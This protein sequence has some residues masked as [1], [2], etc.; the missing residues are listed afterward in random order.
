MRNPNGYGGV[1][2]LSGNRRRPYRVRVTLGWE[3][4]E[5]GSRLQKYT[6]IGYY[7]TH[8]D[9]LIALAQFNQ[10]PFDL[11]LRTITFGQVYK[12]WTPR[13]FERYPSTRRVTE[14]AMA[15]CRD[16]WDRWD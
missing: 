3:R 11:S 4:R 13:Q 6:T 7:S 10:M 9:A 1:T 12:Q 14:S 8:E 16:L 5:D 15:L 2:K